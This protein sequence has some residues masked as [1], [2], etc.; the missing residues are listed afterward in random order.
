LFGTG[1]LVT[2]VLA[3]QPASASANLTIC[4]TVQV[5]VTIPNVTTTGEITGDYCDPATGNG[6]LLLLVAGGGENADYWNMPELA[7]N[8]L[9]TAAT[10]HGYATFAIDRIGTGRSTLPASSTDVTYNAQVSTVHQVVTALR[11]QPGLFGGEHWNS[12]VGV[13][14]SLGSGTL[15]G[16]AANNP[17]DVSALVLTGYG[18]AVTPQTLQLDALY[19]KPANTLSTQWANLDSGYVSVEPDAVEDIG[20]LYP[21]GTSTAGLNAASAHQGTLSTTELSTRPQGA[22]AIALGSEITL[23]VD[24]LDGQYDLHYCLGNAVGDP[25][26]FTAQCQS[27]SAFFSYEQ[28]LVPNACLQTQLIDTSGHAIEEEIAA[29][30]AN[31]AYLSWISQVLDGTIC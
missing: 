9:V 8:S 5:P 30:T 27:A 3:A 4:D 25:V 15:V 19:Q 22:N 31:S 11:T 6:T 16:V 13:G 23:P 21:P 29:P 14:H 20:L 28:Q 12:I 18:A 1:V 26:S 2:S 17:G 7:G 10:Q 24:V